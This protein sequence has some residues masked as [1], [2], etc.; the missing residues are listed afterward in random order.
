MKKTLR[1]SFA[2]FTF[3]LLQNFLTGQT[4]STFQCASNEAMQ[5][6]PVLLERQ[7]AIEKAI[8][9]KIEK[10]GFEKSNTLPYVLPVVVHIIHDNG[11]GD[12]PD[13]QVF[14]AM[15]QLNQAFAHQDYYANQGDGYDTQ[16]QFCLAKRDPDGNATNGIT[17]TH[18]PL[19]NL[20]METE[21]SAMK[22]LSRWPPTDYINVWV[23]HEVSSQ[24]SGP[25]VAGY[26]YLASSHG[27][28]FDGIVCEASFFGNS[29]EKNTVFI[30][31]MGHYLN[32]YHTF[33]DGCPNDDCLSSGDRVCDTPPD[34]VTFSGCEYN[35]CDTDSD[36]VSSNN[37]FSS[38]LND[39]TENYM[40]YSPFECYHAFTEGQALRMHQAI[41][42]AR[43]SLLESDGCL[44]PCTLPII[45]D[46]S[47]SATEIFADEAV[48][49]T[50]LTTG[51]TVY[52]WSVGG[53]V[54]SNDFDAEYTFNDVGVFEVLLNAGN[55]DE[56]CLAEASIFINV[57]CP[58]T[59]DF[60]VNNTQVIFGDTLF[61]SNLSQNATTYEWQI[62][63]VFIDNTLDLTYLFT[64]P[65]IYSLLLKAV[66]NNC[67]DNHSLLI[68]V[69]NEAPCADSI[70]GSNWQL[71]N[72]P[73]W[74]DIH[75][76]DISPDGN[77]FLNVYHAW[78]SGSI[79]KT[80][81]DGNILWSKT[82]DI[83]VN[84]LGGSSYSSIKAQTDGGCIASF[85]RDDHTERVVFKT[86]ANGN[87][88]WSKLVAPTPA[89][90][91]NGFGDDVFL[92]VG[93]QDPEKLLVARLDEN[94][95][96][97]W[98]KSYG[99][100]NG[101]QVG[102]SSPS[103]DGQAHWIVGQGD[104]HEGVVVKM[105]VDGELIFAKKYVETSIEFFVFD[106]V[107]GTPGGGFIAVGR[108]SDISSS[109]P[110][111]DFIILKAD[112][113]GEVEWSKRIDEDIPVQHDIVGNE[114]WL[115]PDN[116]GY[117]AQFTHFAGRSFYLS[118]SLNGELEYTK[119]YLDENGEYL[120]FSV[121]KL[122]GGFFAT[123]RHPDNINE[124]FIVDY[125]PLAGPDLG[126]IIQID[127]QLSSVD[128]NWQVSDLAFASSPDGFSISNTT[129]TELTND[130]AVLPIPFCEEEIPCSEIC[131]N[132]LDDDEDGYVDCYDEDCEC[133]DG[134]DCITMLDSFP[135]IKGKIAWQ[136]GDDQV[137]NYATPMVANLDP[138][139]DSIPEI[140]V[141]VGA[142]TN[143]V[144]TNTE[145]LIFKGD[146][147]NAN[148]PDRLTLSCSFKSNNAPSIGDINGDGIPELVMPCLNNSIRV[149]THYVPDGSPC[150]SFMAASASNM[151]DDQPHLILADF[152]SD[153]ISEVAA[154]NDI[155]KFDFSN[156]AAPT[157]SKVLDGTGHTGKINFGRSKISAVDLLST[158]D[159]N[160]DPDCE[161]LELLAGTFIYSIDL[162]PL[163]GD[164]M[165]IKPMR[166]LNVLENTTAFSDGY[167][168]SADMDLD[169]VLDVVT[170]GRR[171]FNR[172][173]YVWNKNGLLRFIGNDEIGSLRTQPVAIANV[174]DDR[175]AGFQQDLP[176]II[177]LSK[178]KMLCFNLN[179]AESSPDAPYW[180]TLD[181]E[182]NG[183]AGLSCFD[184]NGD[185]YAEILYR[186]EERFRIIHG[187]AAPF[188]AGVDA[189][190]TWWSTECLSKTVEEFP[191]VANLDSDLEAEI[192]FTGDLPPDN[193]NPT[194][195]PSKL[196]VVESDSFPWQPAR[197]VWNQFDYIGVN[198][199]DDL[200]I[201][202]HQQAHHL[203]FPGIG[204]GERPLNMAQTQWPLWGNT[205][206]ENLPVPDAV[207]QIDSSLC[208]ID[209][210]AL[211]LTICNQGSNVLP[212]S[213]PVSFYQN[214]PTT[215]AAVLLI[216][217]PTSI[218]LPID[219]CFAFS[220]KIPA[221]YNTPIFVSVN[222]N[223]T[224]PTPFNLSTDFPNTSVYECNYENNLAHFEVPHQ[225]PTLDLGPDITTC[226]SSTNSLHAGSS[227]VKYRWQDGSTD[228]TFTTWDMGKYWVDA[229]DACGLK[230]SDTVVISLDQA[231]VFDLGDDLTICTGDSVDLGVSSFTDVKW[232]PADELACDDCPTTS[233]T[234]TTSTTYHATASEGNCFSSDSIRITVVE[235]PEILLEAN[236]TGCGDP[237]TL[238]V[239]PVAGTSLDYLWSTGNTGDS[240][241]VGQNG[242]YAVTATNFHGCSTTDSV[243]VE[244]P[245]DIEINASILPIP[246]FGG[247]GGIQLEVV[248]AAEPY[249]I[250]WSNGETG[251]TVSNLLAG[252]YSMT[253]SDA[254]GCE[255]IEEFML[256][257]PMEL[258]LSPIVTHI[259]C[260][261]DP[262]SILLNSSGGN[263][264]LSYSWSHG[265]NMDSIAVNSPGLYAATVTDSNGCEIIFEQNIE[266][267]EPLEVTILFTEIQCHGGSDGSAGLIPLNGQSPYQY[268]WE[269]GAIDSLLTDLDTAPHTVT[270]TDAEDCEKVLSFNLTEPDS[271][272]ID[273]I[274]TPVNCFGEMNGTAL[275]EVTGGSPSYSYSWSNGETSHM[276]ENLPS[277]IYHL[278]ITDEHGCQDSTE[279]LI[280]EPPLLEVTI[281]ANP[282]EVCP[283][284]MSHVAATPT[285]GVLPY[286]YLWNNM[287]G[288]S[289]LE[290]VIA[291]LFE[292][293]VTDSNGCE[294]NS[295]FILEEI[296][297]PISVQDSIESA[298]GAANADGTILLEMI[299]GGTPPFTFLWSNGDTTQSVKGLLPGNY[300]LTITDAI[301][302]SEEFE[303][304]VDFMVSTFLLENGGFEVSLFPNPIGQ[305]KDG[306]LSINS[307][308]PQKI[309]YRLFD[310]TGRK[311]MESKFVSVFELKNINIK[312]PFVAGIYFIEIIN[313]KGQ[314]AFVKWVVAKN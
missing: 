114:V 50:N 46:F 95:D 66:G 301:S 264:L 115:K 21:D 146:G 73:Y 53:S 2:F 151:E 23:V 201:P 117:I 19:T 76:N 304:E 122:N 281:V 121:K 190:R 273:I 294:T 9:Q 292:V 129:F 252:I 80:K 296:S 239:T 282:S 42:F 248:Q 173:T 118:Y 307:I 29:P 172:G 302:C 152:D 208:S 100:E 132:S 139:N 207:V 195:L 180:W 291:G 169:G 89:T 229:W 198:I 84:G 112:A 191:V 131:D 274:P 200:S 263:G 61:V 178:T 83:P 108:W 24:S 10:S 54:F 177:T 211:W 77:Y 153:G 124:M 74:T 156:P 203:E 13:A 259:S 37:P 251:D 71:Q 231:A 197:P 155:F 216:T 215:G 167:S 102:G 242:T 107:E 236:I 181:I 245:I 257:D 199:N 196:W 297:S 123:R 12:I 228:S 249:D 188:P 138:W 212:D 34:Q 32:L 119:S 149:Y 62:N 7:Q 59:A 262:G 250:I 4:L 164:G 78:V 246:C 299:E 158:S 56:N 312:S 176:E 204:S 120:N 25:G 174:Y 20:I 69:R 253:L 18:S 226:N 261:N 3:L 39:L 94:G 183:W 136:S 192:V 87:T 217:A 88:K 63:G 254:D 160:G 103:H 271:I 15:E 189:E 105:G 219:S 218:E 287:A 170:S 127:E 72:A 277:G 272:S 65:G 31:E 14:A 162:D 221:V 150:M 283:G 194:V 148:N 43:S 104:L 166:D 278:T 258:T 135:K 267:E 58:V 206:S 60:T 22:D 225:S 159:C 92:F 286:T 202:K 143:S 270:I 157:L 96:I 235:Y 91:T 133:F 310:V 165:E 256:E 99:I 79:I 128:F 68:E 306:I 288:D 110:A 82:I 275:A 289:L 280:V 145:L 210:I 227:F 209:S 75:F 85:R 64:T 298:T 48:S 27:E 269:N 233:A 222:D 5:S 38:D 313:E 6:Q 238:T 67:N 184:F 240:I 1:S 35:S 140:I 161:G 45:A 266:M 247:T 314:L 182:D 144:S 49:F 125:D 97:L 205:Y 230:Q 36:D 113:M 44:D 244:I 295:D 193:N 171:F 293:V 40:D 86:D 137:S 70:T 285:G 51:G 214:N 279:I 90:E 109:I 81:S 17:R 179:I 213:L 106:R 268:K 111:T 308:F 101:F 93:D 11:V 223:G 232:W 276:I 237:A 185:N 175:K 243:H 311:L 57:K 187:G 130:Y 142:S 260:N 141:P 220:L 300:S 163:D 41:E 290:N 126:C 33:Q 224:L 255:V 234:P 47:A 134:E 305:N 26:A 30:H 186:D 147:S 265:P 16:I 168:Y 55:D 154:Y 241:Q 303:F 52:E 116:N 98:N 309:K 284:E 28:P 8:L